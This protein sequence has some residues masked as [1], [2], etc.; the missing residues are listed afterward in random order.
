MTHYPPPQPRR[1]WKKTTLITVVVVV[2]VVFLLMLKIAIKQAFH[3]NEAAPKIDLVEQG[4]PITVQ[5][6]TVNVTHIGG[7]DTLGDG[8][9][10]QK[11]NGIWLVVQMH[12][13][14]D[15]RQ[16]QTFEASSQ[17]LIIANGDD[18]KQGRVT[19]THIDGKDYSPYPLGLSGLG[20]TSVTL[21][22]GLEGYVT[23][24]YDVPDWRGQPTNDNGYFIHI[25]VG[26][27][28]STSYIV[29]DSSKNTTPTTTTTPCVGL[30]S[31]CGY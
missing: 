28:R 4:T 3:P 2:A 19:P 8:F 12:V 15:S 13:R 10:T 22:P 31:K 27:M 26:Y 5:G 18:M 20:D 29:L 6:V 16:E 30:P 1:N 11:P 23:A 24:A 21:N 17:H 14:N 9:F 7:R 25:E